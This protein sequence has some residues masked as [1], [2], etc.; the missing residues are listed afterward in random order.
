MLRT[1]SFA[2]ETAPE[3]ARVIR[4]VRG[5]ALS[6]DATPTLVWEISGRDVEFSP[7]GRHVAWEELHHEVFPDGVRYSE[8][9]PSLVIGDAKTMRPRFRVRSATLAYGDDYVGSHWLADSSG[10]VAAVRAEGADEGLPDGTDGVRR[11]PR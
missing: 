2:I 6:P 8:R 7:D 11:R 1:D 5:V 4:T 3:T 9:W 10:V